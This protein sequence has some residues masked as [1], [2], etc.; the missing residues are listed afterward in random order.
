M[1]NLYA[2]EI[3]VDW[4]GREY[5]FRPSLSAI[6]SLGEPDELTEML[7]RIQAPGVDGFLCALNVMN[8]CY[9][10][11]A[12]DIDKLV[13]VIRDVRGRLR[14]V[15]G[16]MPQQE[17]HIIGARLAISG[18]IGKPKKLKKGADAP[19]RSLFDPGAFVAAAQ[20]GLGVSASEGW[21]MTMLELQRALDAKNPDAEDDDDDLT[22]QE[23]QDAIDRVHHIRE[24]IEKRRSGGG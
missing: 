14:Y 17:V 1:A 21:A 10:G 12:E 8:A 13:G 15:A 24:L 23:A 6:A 2:G 16:A 5:L 7:A 3:G 22:E 11:D 19:S 20:A 18:M 4:K 9:V